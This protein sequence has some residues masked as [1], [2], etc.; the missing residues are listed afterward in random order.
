MKRV[1]IASVSVAIASLMLIPNSVSADDM[2]LEVEDRVGD[3]AFA[4]A[5]EIFDYQVLLGKGS[6]IVKAGYFDMTLFW[7]GLEDGTHTYGM[8]LAADL[9]EEGDPLPAGVRILQY[10]LWLDKDSWDWTAAVESYFMVML[11]YDG[12]EYSAALLE[13]PSMAVI[14]QLPFAIDGPRFEVTFSADSIDN[15]QSFW[16]CVGV[17]AILGDPLTRMW[18]DIFDYDAGAPGQVITSIPWPPEE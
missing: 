5:Y 7:F 2:Y 15:I 4:Y 1:T 18:S 9:P 17:L 6:P 12:L 11:Q 13:W 14:M 3:V 10:M 8:Q 16:L